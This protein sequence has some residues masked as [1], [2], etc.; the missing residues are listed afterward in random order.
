MISAGL[1][2]LRALHSFQMCGSPQ[3]EAP[4]QV[5]GPFFTG[6]VGVCFSLL[7]VQCPGDGSLTRTISPTVSYPQRPDIISLG[8]QSQ[9]HRLCGLCT[10]VSFGVP[11]VEQQ[12]M[13]LCSLTSSLLTISLSQHIQL[14]CLPLHTQRL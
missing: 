5:D 3:A 6:R 2:S 14:A 13:V 9:A 1:H 11:N 8:H 12:I 7:S 10:L 4:G